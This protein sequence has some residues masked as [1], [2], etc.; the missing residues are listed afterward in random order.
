MST[1]QA[2]PNRHTTLGISKPSQS[3]S[4]ETR[5]PAP[6]EHI[7]KR[8]WLALICIALGVSI[9]IMDATIVNV[10]LPVV[11]EDLGLS[12][13]DAQWTNAAYSSS[14]QPCC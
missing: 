9:V 3:P 12:A 4:T 7:D 1:P 10:A 8:G 5:A 6:Q 11:I 13:A 14:S 2:D